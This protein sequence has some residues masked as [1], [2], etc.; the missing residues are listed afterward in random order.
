M[1]PTAPS[2]HHWNEIY[3]N[4]GHIWGEQES[5]T[6]ERMNDHMNPG[7]RVFD[8]GY[9][10]GRDMLFLV[11]QGHRVNGVETSYI[12]A[13][14]A[15]D[16]LKPHADH[17]NAHVILGQ[18]PTLELIDG[19]YDAAY[20]HCVFEF[21]DAPSQERAYA[22]KISQ[23]LRADAPFFV[24]V[25]SDPASYKRGDLKGHWDRNRFNDVFGNRFD[26]Q[27]FEEAHETETLNGE[28]VSF[29]TLMMKARRKAVLPAPP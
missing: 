17:G 3:W 2:S 20:S 6:A 1:K 5:L 15:F 22:E 19:W 4:E 16:K 10:Y 21:L 14:H 23:L 9:G 18:F 13:E 7:S 27:G 25:C 28:S 11:Q 12:A 26:I 29:P 8:I 24:S